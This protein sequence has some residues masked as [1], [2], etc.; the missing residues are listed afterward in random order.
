MQ[1]RLEVVLLRYAQISLQH[2]QLQRDEFSTLLCN[3]DLNRCHICESEHF[4]TQYQLRYNND[5]V[6]HINIVNL[7]VSYNGRD[8]F[9]H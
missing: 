7:L 4:S 9:A 3:R 8:E 2:S 5:I 6:S 1:H